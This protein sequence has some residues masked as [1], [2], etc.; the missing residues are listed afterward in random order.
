LLSPYTAQRKG[1]AHMDLLL[2]FLISVVA[3]VVGYYI[4]KWLGRNDKDS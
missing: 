1:G 3:S 2:T 4:C